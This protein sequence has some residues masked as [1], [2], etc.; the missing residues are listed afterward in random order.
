MEKELKT[1]SLC[2]LSYER[3][4]FL[5]DAI[6]SAIYEPGIDIDKYEIIVHDDGT[7]EKAEEVRELIDR[8]LDT[9]IINKAIL[10]PPGKNEGVGNAIKTCFDIA[11]GDIL[12][13]ID[14]DLLFKRNWLERVMQLLND[15]DRIALLGLFHYYHDPV[16]S[17]KCKMM[18][19]DGWQIHTHICGSGFAMPRRAY[20]AFG[21]DTHSKAYAE[22]W[23]LMKKITDS[24]AWYNALPDED[25]VEN[26]G[27][28]IGP[29]TV[30]MNDGSV[31]PINKARI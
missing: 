23:E 28:G 8:G 21:I 9:Q 6:T 19:K 13:K 22:D 27:F 5:S 25:L 18:Q 10:K 1:A 2:F 24:V 12:I 4:E 7:Y 14:Q 3:P 20:E 26:R 11:R 30:V 17:R 16:D 15:N 29:S 31:R